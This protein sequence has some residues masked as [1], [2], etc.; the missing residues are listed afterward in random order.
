MRGK[1]REAI[2]VSVLVTLFAVMVIGG[3]K[4][5]VDIFCLNWLGWSLTAFVATLSAYILLN[6]YEKSK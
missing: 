4:L 2:G 3:W 6:V 1:I 5:F